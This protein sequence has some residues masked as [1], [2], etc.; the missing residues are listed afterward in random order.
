MEYENDTLMAG[1]A[2]FAVSVLNARLQQSPPPLYSNKQTSSAQCAK[3]SGISFTDVRVGRHREKKRILLDLNLEDELSKDRL[4]RRAVLDIW[5]TDK[6]PRA[7]IG[8]Y[9]RGSSSLTTLASQTDGSMKTLCKTGE[10][11]GFHTTSEKSLLLRW[12]QERHFGRKGTVL[13]VHD[14]CLFMFVRD[15]GDSV[16]VEAANVCRD[17]SYDV[18]LH[19][20]LMN[21]I[22][23]S[24]LPL[25]VNLG[26][27]Q[28]EFLTAIVK[29]SYTVP[30]FAYKLH[31]DFDVSYDA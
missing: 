1:F 21:M 11:L 10:S 29:V 30:T 22:S 18:M 8:F 25:S 5:D 26:H 17:R 28:R 19:L 4:F 13:H 15:F 14:N 23:L 2:E 7:E 3:L 6:I 9:K 24:P 27:A 12:S 20:S 31:P 16:S